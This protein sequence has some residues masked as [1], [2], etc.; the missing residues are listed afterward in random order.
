MGRTPGGGHGD[1]LQYFYLE[2]PMHRGAWWATVH[3]VTKSRTR[4]S[5]SAQHSTGV[6]T[7]S[8][9]KTTESK[10]AKNLHD[11][12]SGNVRLRNSELVPVG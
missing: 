12:S 9:S 2:N 10:L 4:L 3:G 1:P 5:D 6:E 11:K 8:R 7:N